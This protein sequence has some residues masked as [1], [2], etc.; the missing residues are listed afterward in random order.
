MALVG[1]LRSPFFGLSDGDLFSISQVENVEEFWNKFLVY[2]S[3]IASSN[4]LNYVSKI[5]KS[6]LSI[7]HRVPISTLIR[8]IVNETGMI[9]VLSV[10]RQGEQKWANY[11]KLLQIAR[12]FDKNDNASLSSFLHQLDLLMDTDNQ[13]EQA[14]TDND[15]DRVQI[16][17]IHASKGLELSLIHI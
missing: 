9:G 12:E 15:L 16:M 1:I 2:Q 14:K 7:C 8:R 3:E 11:Q 17:T 10:G 6:H 4:T 5:L 13:E